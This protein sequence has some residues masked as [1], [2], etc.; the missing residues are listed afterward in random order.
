MT[1]EEKID[2]LEEQVKQLIYI[3]DVLRDDM[4]VLKERVLERFNNIMSPVSTFLQ[5]SRKP[6]LTID[7]VK[8]LKDAEKSL[9]EYQ[10]LLKEL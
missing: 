6:Y 1:P 3:N 8:M 4:D 5:V 2:R 9:I 10:T 7:R